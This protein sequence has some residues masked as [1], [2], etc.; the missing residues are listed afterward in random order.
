[1]L[2]PSDARIAKRAF[3]AEAHVVALRERQLPILEASGKEDTSDFEE[4]IEYGERLVGELLMV[5][6]GELPATAVD[7]RGMNRWG[8]FA[9][10]VLRMTGPS[11]Y[12]LARDYRRE[13][14]GGHGA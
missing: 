2:R 8:K 6:H 12:A 13:L 3:E 9:V 10:S 14:D 4:F 5:A 11:G 7:R 1:M